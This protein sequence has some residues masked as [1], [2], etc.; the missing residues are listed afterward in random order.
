[1]PN[2]LL[3]WAGLLFAIVVLI[4]VLRLDM[5]FWGALKHEPKL[6]GPTEQIPADGAPLVSVVIPAKD[7]EAHIEQSARSILASRYEPL[8]LI[9]VNDRSQDRTLAIMERLACEDQ[10]IKVVSV[11]ALPEGWTGKTHAMFQGAVRA[12]G[13]I[14]LFTDADAVLSPDTL[15]RA[16]RFLKTHSVD[17]MSLLPGFTDRGFIEDAV[18]TH[19]SFGISF[20]YPLHQVNDQSNPAGLASGCFIMI[21]RDAY[22]EIGT[23][24]RM[25]NEVTEDV[26]LSK[27]L[28]AGGRKLLVL[29]AGEMVR[30]KPFDRLG[31]VCRFWQRTYYGAL[32]KSIPKVLRLFAN[33][34]ALLV[35]SAL[36]VVSGMAWLT[37]AATLPVGLLFV[38]TVL[39][40]AAVIIPAAVIIQQERGHWAY[41]LTM[42]VGV[43]IAAW[44]AVSTLIRILSNEGIRW[45][46]SLYK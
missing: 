41:G 35:M 32:E 23:W 14:L 19:L 20:F 29:R 37:G 46:G 18:H 16:I 42:P 31:D 21:R 17:M 3:A 36:F 26:A 15:P 27:V 1:M 5:L 34:V 7:E 24:A 6:A 11:E 39:A 25:K 12:S 38:V 45:R 28:K 2:D 40:M 43:L 4:E 10:R 30:T 13:E 9:L 33:Y 22:E 44:V 8:E